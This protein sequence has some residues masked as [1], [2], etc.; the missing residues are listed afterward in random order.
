MLQYRSSLYNIIYLRAYLLTYLL[1]YSMEQSHFWEAY[2]PSASQ[3]IPR[4][5][6]NQPAGSL[7]HSQM[8][9]LFITF[10]NLQKVVHLLK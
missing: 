7:P 6:W 8:S 2:R 3:E 5:L 1:T 4:I 10:N 9:A